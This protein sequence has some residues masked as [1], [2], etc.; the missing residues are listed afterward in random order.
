MDIILKIWDN[1]IFENILK[2]IGFIIIIYFIIN[3]RNIGEGKVS[4][5]IKGIRA[6]VVI[7]IITSLFIFA[8]RKD[9]GVKNFFNGEQAKI[10][11]RLEKED[12]KNVKK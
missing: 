7:S 10:E 4:L 8:Y 1:E 11:N 5:N 2:L 6:I 3:I 9:E 12:T